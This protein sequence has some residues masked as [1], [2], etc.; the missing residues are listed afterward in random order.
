MMNQ[1]KM[2]IG[3]VAAFGFVPG[4]AAAEDAASP[5]AN[6]AGVVQ[7]A[8]K[9]VV[10]GAEVVLISESGEEVARATSGDDGSY[11]LG[12]VDAGSYQLELVGGEDFKG[13]K[14]AAPVG[15]N[16]LTVAWAVDEGRPALASATATG[17]AC[18]VTVAAA[19]AAPAAAEAAGAA[20]GEALLGTTAGAVVGG[21]ALA[22]GLGLGI[23]AGYGAF[24]PDS[25]A[26]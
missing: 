6:V 5:Q 15:P 19:A 9:N 1:V 21:G 4:V 24:S 22:T 12:C 25:P 20:G 16:G 11:A 8:D 3:L 23:A 14:V 26:Q 10:S 13:Q 17:G 2:M 18:G 7:D